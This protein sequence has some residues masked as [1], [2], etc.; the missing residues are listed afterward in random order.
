MEKEKLSSVNSGYTG[1][2][3][4]LLFFALSICGIIFLALL[5]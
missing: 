3:M 2:V 1:V 4:T 5:I